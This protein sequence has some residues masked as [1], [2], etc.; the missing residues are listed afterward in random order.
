MLRG[1]VF[2]IL[3]DGLEKCKDGVRDVG[4]ERKGCKR[5]RGSKRGE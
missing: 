5:R 3:D 1:K 2:V 4:R